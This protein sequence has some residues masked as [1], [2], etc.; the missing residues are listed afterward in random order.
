MSNE[1]KIK[2]LAATLKAKGLA[3]S[4]TDALEKARGILGGIEATKKPI[5]DYAAKQKAIED[6]KRRAIASSQENSNIPKVEMQQ[7]QSNNTNSN[8]SRINA[9]NNE[10]DML[11][12]KNDANQAKLDDENSKNEE[13]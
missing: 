13:S 9:I 11:T 4:T 6:L 12:A 2:E 5:S 3:C 7:T 10:V 8:D 1:Q